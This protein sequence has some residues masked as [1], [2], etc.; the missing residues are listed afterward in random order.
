M[1]RISVALVLLCA[2]AVLLGESAA[3]QVFIVSI[4]YNDP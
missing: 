3:N 4:K 1:L 2:L